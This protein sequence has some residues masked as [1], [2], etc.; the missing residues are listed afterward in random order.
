M[1]HSSQQNQFEERRKQM[2]TN[3]L[4]IVCALIAAAAG[5][6][7]IWTE[8]GPEKKVDDKKPEKKDTSDEIK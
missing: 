2:G 7:V 1:T 4:A 8:V 6:Y 5:A 3:I